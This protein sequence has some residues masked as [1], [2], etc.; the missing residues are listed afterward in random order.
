MALQ[1]AILRTHMHSRHSPVPDTC[2]AR[3]K[4]C[5]TQISSIGLFNIKSR[6]MGFV[7]LTRG[8]SCNSLYAEC[9]QQ[10]EMNFELVTQSFHSSEVLSIDTCIRKP[11]VASVSTDHT[12]RLW[13]FLDK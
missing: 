6:H 4:S 11:I 10:D 1:P 7:H 9:L 13:N 5:S 8:Q 12:V 2:H 3:Q